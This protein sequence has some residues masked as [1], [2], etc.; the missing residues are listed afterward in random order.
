MSKKIKLSPETKDQIDAICDKYGIR[1]EKQRCALKEYI[2]RQLNGR[3]WDTRPAYGLGRYI[4]NQ[5]LC[6]ELDYMGITNQ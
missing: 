3:A 1:R 4:D 6:K 5:Y 2:S